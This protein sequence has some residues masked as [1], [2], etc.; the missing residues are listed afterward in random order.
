[1][2]KSR[3]RTEHTPSS[4]RSCT[5]MAGKTRSCKPLSPQDATK[6]PT[7]ELRRFDDKKRAARIA[8]VRPLRNIA[9]PGS[10]RSGPSSCASALRKRA[11]ASSPMS[12]Q[13]GRRRI[14]SNIRRSRPSAWASFLAGPVPGSSC[15]MPEAASIGRR[16][17][18][19][20]DLDLDLGVQR[21]SPPGA[22]RVP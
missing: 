1:M 14:S 9:R 19:E 11:G 15:Q 10:G 12:S 4:R 8:T 22:G 20:H 21:N 7:K 2:A 6:L 3:E 13:L 18:L 5:G 17:T 16:A